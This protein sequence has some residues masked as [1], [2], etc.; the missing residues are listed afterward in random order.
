M[1]YSSYIS[2]RKMRDMKDIEWATKE[3]IKK[4]EEEEKFELEYWDEIP[5]GFD[6][7][8]KIWEY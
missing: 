5:K 4:W 1:A 7:E 8:N 6:E 2:I 3:E